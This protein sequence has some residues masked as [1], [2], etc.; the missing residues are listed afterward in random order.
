MVRHPPLSYGVNQIIIIITD[1]S[2]LGYPKGLHLFF[3]LI[4]PLSLYNCFMKKNTLYLQKKHC[5]ESITPDLQFK[6]S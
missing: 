4:A 5:F 3:S 1:Y 6:K 2:N